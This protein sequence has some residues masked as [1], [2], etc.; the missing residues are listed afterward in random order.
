MHQ[1]HIDIMQALESQG[2]DLRVQHK[3]VTLDFTSTPAT[4]EG[5]GYSVDASCVQVKVT[6]HTTKK[7]RHA[8]K[9]MSMGMNKNQKVRKRMFVVVSKRIQHVTR[10]W[11]SASTTTSNLRDP[12]ILKQTSFL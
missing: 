8:M 2:Q 4:E 6:K 5:A 10:V 11:A 9:S 3:N 12:S 7:V 1:F